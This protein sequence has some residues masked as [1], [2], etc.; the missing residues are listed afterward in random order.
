[1]SDNSKK[2]SE[3]PQASNVA[4]TDRV[5]IL[6]DP[7]GAAS[8]RTIT[9]ENLSISLSKLITNNVAVNSATVNNTNYK[10][11]ATA[12]SLTSQVQ[13]V[14]TNN[15]DQDHNYYL[16]NGSQGQLMYIATKTGQYAEENIKIWMENI[17]IPNGTVISDSYWIYNGG[18]WGRSAA[19]AIYIDGAW[20]IDGGAWSP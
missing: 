5:V 17:R 6:R 15:L 12:L 1:M 9:T 18:G 4:L 7:S 8:A 3:L 16:P 10:T 11:N 20:N 14:G 13:I 2:L 19:F